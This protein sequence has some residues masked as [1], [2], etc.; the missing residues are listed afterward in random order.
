MNQK[1]I[2]VLRRVRAVLAEIADSGECDPETQGALNLARLE[3]GELPDLGDDDNDDDSDGLC[4]WTVGDDGVARLD[5]EATD[6]T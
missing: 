4:P 2:E 5:S 6:A 1:Q 3:L